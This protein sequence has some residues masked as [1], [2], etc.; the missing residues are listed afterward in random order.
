MKKNKEMILVIIFSLIILLVLA[1]GILSLQRNRIIK[2][3]NDNII[4]EEN[5]ES[6]KGQDYETKSSSDMQNEEKESEETSEE[7]FTK[8]KETSSSES[9]IQP[10]EREK[11]MIIIGDSRGCSLFNSVGTF[12]EWK[13]VDEKRDRDALDR[14]WILYER[15]GMKLFICAFGGGNFANKAYENCMIRTKEEILS[16]EWIAD[17]AEIRIVNIFGLGDINTGL[18][19]NS[20]RHYNDCDEEF[21]AEFA[22]LFPGRFQYYHCTVGPIDEEGSMGKSGVWTNEMIET[23]NKGFKESEHVQIIDLY[24]DFTGTFQCVISE[25]DPTGVHYTI[26]TDREILN[27]FIKKV[28]K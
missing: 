7:G 28:Y 12:S 8:E 11:C 16:S 17:D 14:G 24:H 13:Y 6:E 15:D 10:V 3:T 9:D 20:P 25:A 23:F 27:F 21:A 1:I 26:D 22:E 2:N 4:S 19:P 18:Y 5:A